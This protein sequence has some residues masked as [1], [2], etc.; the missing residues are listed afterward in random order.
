MYRFTGWLLTFGMTVSLSMSAAPVGHNAIALPSLDPF[1]TFLD[2]HP[3]D[4]SSSNAQSIAAAMPTVVSQ[5]QATSSQDRRQIQVPTVVT[6]TPTPD[7]GFGTGRRQS[8]HR[9]LHWR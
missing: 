9:L 5:G 3:V 2:M 6:P 4:M 7:Q 8:R 1:V